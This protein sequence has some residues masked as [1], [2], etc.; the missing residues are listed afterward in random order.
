VLVQIGSLNE[1]SQLVVN[2]ANITIGGTLQVDLL[3][4][5]KPLAG[6]TFTILTDTT[7]GATLSGSFDAINSAVVQFNVIYNRDPS[8]I[9][10][11]LGFG[12]VAGLT[13]NQQ[14]V[15]LAID[16]ADSGPAGNDPKFANVVNALAALNTQQLKS[17]EDAISPIGLASMT[18]MAI[19]ADS[20]VF[21]NMTGRFDDIRNGAAGFSGSVSKVPLAM[22]QDDSKNAEPMMQQ[23]VVNQ[24]S[25][26]M[27]V[28]GGF[29]N[30]G[31]SANGF[32]NQ[33]GYSFNSGG[34]MIGADYH[35]KQ[36]LVVGIVGT[37]ENGSSSVA[38]GASRV[39][40]DGGKIGVYG[41]WWQ[42]GAQG[43][44]VQGYV[45]GG[46]N[47]YDTERNIAI[48]GLP[49]ST[50]RGD[51]E[52]SEFNT[53]LGTG[54]EWTKGNFRFGPTAALQYDSIGINGFQ[55]TG[56]DALDL[57]VHDQ[58]ASSLQSLVGARASYVWQINSQQSLVPYISA[59]WEHEYENGTR[60][61]NADLEGQN[62]S[63]TT[64]SLGNDGILVDAGLTMNWNSRVSTYVTYQG[65]LG[66]TDYTSNSLFAGV[67]V[68][69]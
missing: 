43:A 16:A 1:Y 37:Y 60:G 36:N 44:Y 30:V 9:L 67:R 41:T 4:G 54:Y 47:N 27:S 65:E 8:I 10:Q 46:C 28:I 5:Y 6:Q 20:Q 66:R 23:D 52:S 55:E 45:G 29:A 14:H 12:Q 42:E 11:V 48:G 34:A 25:S 24:W 57:R 15:A 39:N 32:G 19:S 31:S 58:N 3:G 59:K 13:P 69:F 18:E 33:P 7:L 68:N 17:A 26:W 38:N 61:I 22:N 56:A 53:M 2:G 49:S 40:L 21:G 64:G 63:V 35:L 51:T 50:A 62:F